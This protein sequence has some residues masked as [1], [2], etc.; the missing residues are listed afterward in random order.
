MQITEEVSYRLRLAEG[1][2][3]EARQDLELRR[4]RSCVDNSQ[5][6]VEN[7]A[8][9]VLALLGPVGR[10][11]NPAAILRQGLAD[12]LFSNDVSEYVSKIAEHAELLGHD[13]H[14]E[15]DYGSEVGW[16]TPWEL[17]DEADADQSFDI[18]EQA[19]HLAKQT[20]EGAIVLKHEET[21]AS[22]EAL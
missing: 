12:G 15:T 1:F 5:L 10:T 20:I 6:S 11:H 8:K 17:F 13:V 2:L 19:V 16:R 18:A 7:A 22:S 4:W 21:D 14:M 3:N 9:A